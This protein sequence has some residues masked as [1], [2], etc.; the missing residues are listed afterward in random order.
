MMRE[1]ASLYRYLGKDS[2]AEILEKKAGELVPLLMK[3]YKGDGIWNS[4]YP[5]NKQVEVRHC[6]DFMFLGRYLPNDIPDSTRQEMINFVYRELMTKTWMRAQSLQDL[7]AKNSDRPDHGPLGAYDGWPA[8]TMDALTQMGYPQKA[9]DFYHAIEPVTYEGSW[10]QAH[11]LWGE[12]R[13]N[14]NSRVRIAERG[15]HAR[16]ASA[17][18]AIAQVMLKCFFGFNPGFN[19]DPLK[20][21]GAPDLNGTLSPYTV[22]K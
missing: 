17:G 7:A 20:K 5:D 15:W 21:T 8:G 3:L 10:A 11:E 9:L 1:T 13:E 6:L 18:T 4:L 16:D 22:Q 12:N 14:A 19:G 2:K